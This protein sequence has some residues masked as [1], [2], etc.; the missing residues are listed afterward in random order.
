MERPIAVVAAMAAENAEPAAATPA[1]PWP[2]GTSPWRGW[3]GGA[4]ALFREMEEGDAH[5]H[6]VLQTRKNSLLACDWHMA[7][8]DDTPQAAALARDTER[9]L[10]SLPGLDHALFAL[11]D[12]FAR[13]FAVAEVMWR[14]D[15][16]GVPRVAGIVPRRPERFAFDDRG[17][18]WPLDPA[19]DDSAARPR[20]GDGP[21]PRL[22]PRPGESAVPTTGDE[23]RLPDRKFVTFAFQGGPAHPYG[24]P[25]CGRAWW[26]FWLKRRNV[27]QW[28][29]FNERF[30]TPTAVARY[31]PA[32]QP[33]EL[34]ALRE[35]LASLQ[36]DAG[37]IIPEGV[38]L[39]LLESRGGG[40]AA[41]FRDFADWCNDELSKIVLGQTLSTGEGRRSGSLALGRVHERVRHEYLAAD[42]RALG[43]ALSTQLV[44]WMTDFAAG[45]GVAAPRMA[46]DTADPAMFREQL[47]L[48]RELV[49]LGVALPARHFYEAYRRAAPADG[50]RGLRYDDAN[51]YQY[52]LQF[53]VL[54]VNE[55]RASL[56]LAPV[57]WGDRPT[58]GL[59]GGEARPPA[60]AD[61]GEETDG[62]PAE[63]ASAE[64]RRERRR[65]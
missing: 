38:A 35:A 55:V 18:L 15:A 57:P 34:D 58:E 31:G 47:E 22:V 61:R 49:K 46:F 60:N 12:A 17:A 6:A 24:T 59:P 53:G 36:R 13:G 5:L 43:G 45:P 33:E 7:P 48:D 41:T 26:L 51:L 64:L 23:V 9:A 44:R 11:L 14:R 21:R 32:T 27:S 42:A 39:E 8:A 2:W 56:G 54:T 1:R 40:Q 3:P 30:G 25:L 29:S 37:L 10:R 62:D 52:H 16:A 50:E 65:R 63:D 4:Y 28:A 20:A 19:R